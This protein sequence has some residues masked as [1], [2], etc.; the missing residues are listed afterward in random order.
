MLAYPSRPTDSDEAAQK[1]NFKERGVTRVARGFF[2]FE[3]PLFSRLAAPGTRHRMP[4][5]AM[6]VPQHQQQ[7]RR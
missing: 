3:V 7:Q 2:V 5:S 4:G 6:R 1:G